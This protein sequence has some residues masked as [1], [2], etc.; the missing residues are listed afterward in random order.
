[1]PTDS[2]S[3][4]LTVYFD[5]QYWVAL[6]EQEEDGVLAVAR[7]VFGPEPALPEIAALVTGPHWSRLRLMPAGPIETHGDA[8]P[9]NPKRR[10]R[11]AAKQSRALSPS[12]KS[13]EALAAAL[14]GQRL[15][16]AASERERRS[17]D[18]E[19]RWQQRVAKRKEKRRGR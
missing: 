17:A 10:Q 3:T 16:S 5:G 14:E 7:H 12:T 19:Q 18:A 13:Q 6:I 4:T 8:L 2:V 1:M 9:S 15:E 11:E